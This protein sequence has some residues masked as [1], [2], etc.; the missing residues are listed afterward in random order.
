MALNQLVMHNVGPYL[1]TVKPSVV[2]V[3]LS[4][5]SW[6]GNSCG[7]SSCGYVNNAV[8]DREW[9]AAFCSA[10]S[11]PFLFKYWPEVPE[12]KCFDSVLCVVRSNVEDVVDLKEKTNSIFHLTWNEA[13][14]L[15]LFRTCWFMR[16][17][18]WSPSL[19]VFMFPSRKSTV[20]LG[21]MMGG[22][23]V[24]CFVM[25]YF[26]RWEVHRL[27]QLVPASSC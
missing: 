27:S 7:V 5:E 23:V 3:F 22:R 18:L 24:F 19:G 21:V 12:K 6:T 20:L 16:S 9:R 10:F 26:F 2:P 15:E 1:F 25:S 13:C 14:Y 4:V 17:S 8:S 11:A